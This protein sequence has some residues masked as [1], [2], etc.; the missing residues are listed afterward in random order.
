LQN[1]TE[2]GLK[3]RRIDRCED[4]LEGGD[5]VVRS[6]RI[7]ALE[8]PKALLG[9][10]QWRGGPYGRAT[11][12]SR[13]LRRRVAECEKEFELVGSDSL[14][15]FSRETPFG[16]TA[17]QTVP[18]DRESNIECSQF[19]KQLLGAQNSTY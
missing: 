14:F 7:K 16:S 17:A 9:E 19:R 18:I 12:N 1:R 3:R 2:G 4:A 5:V 10:R 15:Q 8:E 6:L 13:G 11:R